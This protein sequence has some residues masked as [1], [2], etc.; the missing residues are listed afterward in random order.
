[1]STSMNLTMISSL[2]L[3]V[4]DDEEIATLLEKYLARAGYRTITASTGLTV[5]KE[6]AEQA[7]LALD[8]VDDKLHM[9]LV[10]MLLAASQRFDSC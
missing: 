5:A 7:V 3:V 6:G 8:M 4:E 10:G 2:V 9:V 1:M